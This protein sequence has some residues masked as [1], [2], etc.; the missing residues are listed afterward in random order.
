MNEKTRQY[1][2]GINM[3]SMITPR[4]FHLLL[5]YF[6]DLESIWYATEAEIREIKGLKDIAASFV[7]DRDMGKVERELRRCDDLGLELVSLE[8]SA[9]PPALRAIEKPPPV[10]Y[11][12]GD[13]DPDDHFRIAMVGTRK[14]SNYGKRMAEKI[15]GQLTRAGFTI[16]SGMALGIDTFSHQ[17]A[18]N[19][20]GST[21]AVMGTGFGNPY[22]RRNASLMRRIS[23]TGAV[24]TEYPLDQGPTKWTFP[25]RNRVISGLSRGTIVAEA[26]DKSGALIT[27]N[28]AL[29]QGREVF[30]VPGDA[31]RRSMKGTHQLI[32]DGAK[33]VEDA[34]DVIEE[35]SD[36][37]LNFPV[38]KE[39][40]VKPSPNLT[41][42]QNEVYSALD[43]EPVH[44]NDILERVDFP[45]TRLS[46]IIFQLEIDDL[47]ER[48]EGN[49]WAK[50][51]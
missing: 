17:A 44:F 19:A 11:V 48:S 12:K 30:A 13:Y 51:H 36:L 23:R 8:D 33:L 20:G 28:D 15:S 22:P 4:R 35:F 41:E 46:H 27:A 43:Y 3:N 50:V 45:P 21:I 16:V 14:Y 2:V 42:E 29:T 38:N 25:Q 31:R 32:K 26:P 34:A 10:L 47:V 24:F 9:Y 18:I 40:E 1:W 6:P 37:Q 7:E 49:L 5:G 39:A